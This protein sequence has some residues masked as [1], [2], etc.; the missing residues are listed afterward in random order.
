MIEPPNQRRRLPKLTAENGF[1][2][3]RATREKRAAERLGR[4]MVCP[5]CQKPADDIL[6]AVSSK[7][8]CDR[9]G[10]KLH[11]GIVVIPNRPR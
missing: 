6:G 1:Q 11:V 2:A 5:P 10:G 4:L 9:C 3:T 8:R 7:A